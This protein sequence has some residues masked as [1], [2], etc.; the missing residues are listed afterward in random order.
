MRKLLFALLLLTGTAVVSNAQDKKVVKEETT[1]KRTSSVPQKVHNTF[2][3]HKR[4]N[5]KKTKH[6]KVVAKVAN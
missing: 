2:S 5:G 6:K 4:Y 1:T 3:K